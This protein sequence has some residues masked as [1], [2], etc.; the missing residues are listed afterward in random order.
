MYIVNIY[1]HYLHY[2]DNSCIVCFNNNH[3][4]SF[5]H[6]LEKTNNILSHLTYK[7]KYGHTFKYKN[8]DV[9]PKNILFYSPWHIAYSKLAF[10]GDKISIFCNTS[11]P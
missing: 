8:R 1:K 10:I 2:T 11:K 5:T 9:Q 3:E 4:L 7:I 6:N